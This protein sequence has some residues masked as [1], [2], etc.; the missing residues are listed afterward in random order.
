MNGRVVVDASLA[1]MWAVPEPYS[2]AA[3]SLADHWAQEGTQLFAPCLMLAEVNNALYKRIVRGEMNLAAAQAALDVILG[4]SVEIRE[5]PGLQA[6]AMRLARQL[7]RPTSYDCQYL[8]LAEFLDCELWTG[9][10]RF[11]NAVR[12]AFHRVK[13]IGQ[14]PP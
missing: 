3:L 2:Q 9:D 4:F 6:H 11:H 10:Q 5:Q 1:A 12:R 14:H 8:V 13:W 7:R